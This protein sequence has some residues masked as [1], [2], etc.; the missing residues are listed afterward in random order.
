[1]R[2]TSNAPS[3]NRRSFIIAS[4]SAGALLVSIPLVSRVA[5]AKGSGGTRAQWTVYVAV[6]PDNKVTMIS[7]VMDMGQFMRTTGP[8][9]IA[10]EMD[11]DWSL[12]SFSRDIPVPMKRDEKG[13]VTYAHAPIGTGG[14]YAVR[15]NWDYLRNAGA[16]VRR[17]LIEEAAARWNVSPESLTARDSF[18]LHPE[19]DRRLSY[20]ELA[21][22]AAARDIDPSTIKLKDK[23]QY[24]IMGKD[25]RTIDALDMVTGQP[26][27]GIDEEYPNALQAVIDRAPAL[28]AT[29]AGYDREAALAVPGVRELVEI[30]PKFE[31]HGRDGYAQIVSA[32]V[33]VVA[34][35]LWAAMKGK[36]AL[37]TRWQNTSEYANEDSVAQ[38]DAFRRL[39]MSNEQALMLKDDGDI[40]AAF[41]AAD[42]VID[43]TY[44]KPLWA[45]ACMEPPNIIVDIRK[46]SAK[47]VVGHQF[48]H[49]AAV[50]IEKVTGIDALN[51]EIA[52]KRMGGGFGRRGEIDYLLEGA[53]LGHKLG[54]PVKIT[55]LRENDLEND[56]FDAAV[57][58]RVRAAL[59]DGKVVAWH[60]RQAQTRGESE[61]AVFPANVVPNYRAERFPSTSNIRVGPWRSPRQLQWAFA[62]ESMLDELAYAAKQDPLE[63]RLQLMEPRRAYPIEHWSSTEIHSGRMAKCYETAARMAEWGRKRPQGT[64]LGIAG[65]FTFGTYAACVVEVSVSERNGL[66]IHRAWGAID[67]GFAINPNHIRSQMEGGFIDGFSAV[68]FNRVIVRN[69]EVETKNFDALRWVRMRESPLDIETTIIDSDYPPTGVGEP[70][71]APAGAALVNAVFAACGKRIRSLPLADHI[72]I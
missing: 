71:I 70:P 34:D 36:R 15:A 28:G 42:L 68:L 35:T 52:S 31:D 49:R 50:E 20:G 40:D 19:S 58:M 67:C 59:K 3:L 1:M 23:S 30:E 21:A 44:E 61:Y 6:H 11:L 33:A 64:G 12:I 32:G 37:N 17:M 25:A 16:T 4:A 14:S 72:T 69:G 22:K 63:F 7:P 60:H 65:H 27:Y 39:V 10:E 57:A 56:W 13:E 26:L 45:H 47:V 54:K 5:S 48:P 46:D 2:A 62:T 9:I 41:A 38:Q 8:M 53:L 55:W 43:Q 51:V 24:R 18:V 66:E 29:I